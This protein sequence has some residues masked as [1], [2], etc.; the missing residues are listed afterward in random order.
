MSI[1]LGYSQSF[2][3]QVLN[4]T[5]ESDD[6]L[7]YFLRNTNFSYHNSLFTLDLNRLVWNTWNFDSSGVEQDIHK[8]NLLN[9]RYERMRSPEDC[10]ELTTRANL[11]CNWLPHLVQSDDQCIKTVGNIFE[12]VDDNHRIWVNK[13]QTDHDGMIYVKNHLT[14]RFWSDWL[15]VYKLFCPHNSEFHYFP[16]W[17]AQLINN[18]VR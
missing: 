1:Y 17:Y 12:N 10:L 15:I 4:S 6:W 11:L 13:F 14:D 3:S 2:N 8:L 16:K 9:P 18:P 7:L 5:N